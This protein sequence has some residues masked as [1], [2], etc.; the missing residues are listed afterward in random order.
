MPLPKGWYGHLHNVYLQY[1]AERG[2]LA[3]LC[4]VW[5]LIALM[6]DTRRAL[7]NSLGAAWV[8]YGVLA[9]GT[10]VLAEGLFE[11]NLGDSEVLTMF[12]AVIA[13]GY[14]MQREE[15]ALAPS[16]VGQER[17]E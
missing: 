12:L 5:L 4:V 15:A 16:W 9:V 3:L 13:C 2:I 17:C 11:Y 6:R 8:Q 1:A 14:A 10:A 7:T